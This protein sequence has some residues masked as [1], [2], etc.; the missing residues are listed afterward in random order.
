M[1]IHPHTPTRVVIL[2]ESLTESIIKD[3]V[4]FSLLLGSVAL[5]VWI[6]SDALQ[7]CAG[8]G[9]LLSIVARAGGKAFRGTVREAHDYL[10]TL[11][12]GS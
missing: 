5:G 9:W 3:V 1:T 11:S 8:I 12:R 6:N 4:T 7:W 2:S 10:D